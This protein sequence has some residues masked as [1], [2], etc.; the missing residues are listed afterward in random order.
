MVRS[1]DMCLIFRAVVVGLGLL[2]VLGLN[3]FHPTEPNQTQVH[4]FKWPQ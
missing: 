4:P 1:C 3:N 2:N